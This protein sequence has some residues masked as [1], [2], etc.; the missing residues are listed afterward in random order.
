MAANE[1][2]NG[3]W[4]AWGKWVAIALLSIC[5][6]IFQDV[7]SDMKAD[8]QRLD[9]RVAFMQHDKVSRA[10]LREEVQRIL[11]AQEDSKRDILERLEVYFGRPPK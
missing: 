8:I 4:E 6:W 1:R 3:Y 2:I 5:L 11:K 9:D 10:E 7:R